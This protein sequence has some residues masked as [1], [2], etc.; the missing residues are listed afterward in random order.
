LKEDYITPMT[1]PIEIVAGD[2]GGTNARYAIAEI[3]DGRVLKLGEPVTFHTR[4]HASLATSWEAFGRALGRPLPRAAA[5]AVACPIS[6]EILQLTNNPWVIRPANLA[7]ELEVDAVT[8]LN[9]F[10][11]VGHAVTQLEPEDLLHLA[12]PDEG[13]PAEG[14]ITVIGPGTGFGVAHVL[15]RAAQTY[16]IECEGGH[17]DFAPLDTLEDAILA[18]L[19]TRFTRVSVERVVS[20]P[21][22][23]NLYE[24]LAEIEGRPVQILDDPVLWTHAIAGTDALAAAALQRFFLSLGAVAGDLALAQ[25]AAAVVV[26]GGIMPRIAHLL[27]RSGFAERFVAKGRFERFMAAIPVKLI[28]HKQPGLFGVAAAFEAAHP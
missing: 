11:A 4:D 23:K 16:V 28:T 14:V 5:L 27:P 24:A 26:A 2:I 12:G 10:G 13:L 18:K 1:T 21:G 9:D 25:G 17:T 8:L 7:R 20:G 3:A 15:R 22:L 19:R 6:G